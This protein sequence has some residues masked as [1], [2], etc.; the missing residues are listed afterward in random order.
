MMEK[1][2]PGITS[3]CKRMSRIV[4]TVKPVGEPVP[5]DISDILVVIGFLDMASSIL[6]W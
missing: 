2:G 3:G 1:E 4:I 5:A 6:M